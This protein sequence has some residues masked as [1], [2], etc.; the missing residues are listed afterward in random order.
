M[1]SRRVYF[2]LVVARAFL[3]LLPGYI[4]P[5]EFFQSPE[6][7]AGDIFGYQTLRPWEFD[8]G[9]PSRSIVPVYAT[10]GLSFYLLKCI[11][12]GF[13]SITG[14]DMV[15]TWTLFIAQ[16][17][18][19]FVLS[20]LIDYCLYSLASRETNLDPYSLLAL[21][22]SSYPI[23]TF[24]MRPFS[25]SLETVLLML[26]VYALC[27][28]TAESKVV[29]RWSFVLGA[30]LVLGVFTR[31]TFL[32]FGAP[33]GVAYLLIFSRPF[34]SPPSAAHL[35]S[36]SLWALFHFISGV[37]TAAL[38]CIAADSLYYHG[39]HMAPLNN[40][41]YNAA[42]ENLEQ[43]GLHPRY[44]HILVNTPLLFGPGAILA[45]IHL[46]KALRW[47]RWAAGSLF[48]TVLYYSSVMGTLVL[49]LFPHQEARFLLPLT[50][51]IPLS[52]LAS[53]VVHSRK[54]KLTWFLFNG[55]LLLVYGVLHQAG[56]VPMMATL[57][58]EAVFVGNCT[59]FRDG[60]LLKCR[61]HAF[62]SKQALGNETLETTVIFWKTYM[63]PL[64]LLG[65]L[66]PSSNSTASPDHPRVEVLDAAG[67]EWERVRRLL[68][69]RQALP[70]LE[71]SKRGDLL[72][73]RGSDGVYRRTL[74][75][76]PSTARVA[77]QEL[78]HG[79]Q[80]RRITRQFPHVNFDQLPQLLTEGIYLDL[81]VL[82]RN[83]IL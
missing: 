39:V 20:L 3:A 25:N 76:A 53:P 26:A 32:G 70:S 28:A 37:L 74:I 47:G 15:N 65:S 79:V 43:H 52:S 63:P 81:Y 2:G 49:S 42:T 60:E 68:D 45:F 18:V 6:I 8:E 31:I 57:Q 77:A 67:M 71:V 48:R 23:Y 73:A 9:S 12:G 54:F 58:R 83:P 30:F 44:L 11:A 38:F 17:M 14:L 27:K 13:E 69:Q 80:L 24:L 50:L 46:V 1:S 33:V 66:P 40:L 16:R 4:H 22:A 64:H 19:C 61:E 41:L 29:G 5:D 21:F 36:K 62:R 7:A 34:Y 56:L 72:F 78:P 55:L 59:P 51:S 10:T 82:E 35:S 75:V